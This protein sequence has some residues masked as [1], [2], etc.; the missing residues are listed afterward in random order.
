MS[1][2]CRGTSMLSTNNAWRIPLGLFF[3]VPSIVMAVIW[4]IPELRS[5][6]L[7]ASEIDDEFSALQAAIAL[8][9]GQSSYWE[10]FQGVN[11]TRTAIIVVMNFFQQASGQSFVSSYGAVFVRSIGSVNPFNM[12]V[13]NASVNLFM[14]GVSLVL[15]DRIGRR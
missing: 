15:N 12:T 3:I 4:F 10:I 14:C 5:G 1:C 13:I 9:P 6:V 2:I 8:D 7:T 11:R